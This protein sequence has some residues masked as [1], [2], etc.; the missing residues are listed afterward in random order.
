MPELTAIYT[1]VCESTMEYERRFEGSKGERYKVRYGTTPQGPYQYGWTCTCP[2]FKFSKGKMC[3]HIKACQPLRCAWN[4]GALT[5]SFMD[6]PEDGV[7][8]E[9]GGPLRAVGVAV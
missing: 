3:K 6:A 4:E 9:C 5:G 2:A 1:M 7:C 8:P